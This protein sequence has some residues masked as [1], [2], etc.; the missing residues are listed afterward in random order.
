MTSPRKAV[1]IDP[2][3]AL[4]LLP[5]LESAVSAVLEGPEEISA[6]DS[7]RAQGLVFAIGRLLTNAVAGQ[8]RGASILQARALLGMLE[9]NLHGG[10][11]WEAVYRLIPQLAALLGDP[12]AAAWLAAF[13]AEEAGSAEA[14]HV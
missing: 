7:S 12:S 4:A 14:S 2:A 8:D 5:K 6:E 9:D 10:A 1:S 3:A 13:V 11:E